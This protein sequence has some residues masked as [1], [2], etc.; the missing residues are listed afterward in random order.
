[1]K[2]FGVLEIKLPQNVYKPLLEECTQP[3]N[4]ASEFVTGIASKGVSKQY[5]IKKNKNLLDKFVLDMRDIYDRNY[6]GLDDIKIL[7]KGLPLKVNPC[8]YNLQTKHQFVPNH[9][10]D[11]IYSFV[12]WMKIPYEYEEEEPNGQGLTSCF[13]FTYVNTTGNIRNHVYK[14]GK[15]Y[16]G[17]MLMFPSKLQHCVYPFF[18]SNDNR[19]SISGNI[20]LDGG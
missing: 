18:T 6:P 7:T 8:W 16:E 1:M 12:I 15:K 4:D 20:V 14:L 17:T 3:L 19:I 13:E 9:T 5:Y 10:H 11:G 2:N